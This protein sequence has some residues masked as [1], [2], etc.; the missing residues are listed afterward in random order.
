MGTSR[1]FLRLRLDYAN[2][3]EVD[4]GQ[5]YDNGGSNPQPQPGQDW[6]VEQE[7]NVNL[8]QFDDD[9]EPSMASPA[10]VNQGQVVKRNGEYYVKLS[11]RETEIYCLPAYVKY[12]W[13]F[14]NNNPTDQASKRSVRILD[15]YNANTPSVSGQMIKTFEIPLKD[16]NQRQVYAQFSVHI[17]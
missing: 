4:G 15:A 2:A 13:Y 16:P 8:M 17:Y 10:V 3:Q 5:P 9:E 11:F 7:V 14:E 12:V 1:P 6:K